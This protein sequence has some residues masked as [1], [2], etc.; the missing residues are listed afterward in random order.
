LG[1]AAGR[2]ALPER[3]C[4]S[5]ARHAQEIAH[6]TADVVWLDYVVQ[7]H[8]AC[9]R[10]MDRTMI[11]ALQRSARWLGR[12]DAELLGRYVRKLASRA[13]DFDAEERARFALLQRFSE[14]ALASSDQRCP[15]A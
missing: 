7:L 2:V 1:G 4:L 9:G 5:A 6:W 12:L 10:I 15:P 8:L 13:G 14:A 11:L 3:L